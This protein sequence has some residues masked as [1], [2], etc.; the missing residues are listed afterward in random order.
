M[1]NGAFCRRF[2]GLRSENNEVTWYA[3]AVVNECFVCVDHLNI[4]MST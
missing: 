1:T 2:C 4:G 3:W